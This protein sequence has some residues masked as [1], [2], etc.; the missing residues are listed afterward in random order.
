MCHAGESFPALI[1][2]LLAGVCS[3]NLKSARILRCQY[4]PPGNMLGAFPDNVL[5]AKS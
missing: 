1:T 5:Q 3:A 2:L 4:K